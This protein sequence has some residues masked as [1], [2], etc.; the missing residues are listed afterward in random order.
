V[1]FSACSLLAVGSSRGSDEW[2]VDKN[3][4]VRSSLTELSI[5]CIV[6]H[7]DG[8]YADEDSSAKVEFYERSD[9]MMDLRLVHR[10]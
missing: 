3:S 7:T 8:S 10:H 2:T 6:S 9:K 1:D 5:A 4:Y